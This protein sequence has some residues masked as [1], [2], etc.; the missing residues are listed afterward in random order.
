MI[1]LVDWTKLKANVYDYFTKRS[2]E[3][4][5]QIR[6]G[7]YNENDKLS[8]IILTR[9]VKELDL[10][11]VKEDSIQIAE[12][13]K[14]YDESVIDNC[15]KHINILLDTNFNTPSVYHETL[16]AVTPT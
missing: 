16:D 8:L 4:A 10:Q 12:G 7:Q 15:L 9:Y 2:D 13:F 3:V 11:N 6:K 1:K 5:T 14:D